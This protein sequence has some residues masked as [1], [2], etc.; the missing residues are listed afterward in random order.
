LKQV[1]L[2]AWLLAG[3]LVPGGEPARAQTGSPPGV[4]H[5]PSLT[6]ETALRLT[7]EHNPHVQA[8]RLQADAA[9]A[10]RDD[11]GRRPNP[12]L[13]VG[14]ENIGGG[15]LGD[16]RE[17]QLVLS[18]PIELGGDRAA[19]TGLAAARLDAARAGVASAAID[20]EALTTEL[21]LDAWV[22]QESLRRLAEAVTLAREAV[23]SATERLNAGAAPAYERTRATSFM[24]LR[25]VEH[26]RAATALEAAL[27]RLLQQWSG[28][29][30]FDS[31]ALGEPPLE[32]PAA[33]EILRMRGARH[34]DRLKAEAAR[35]EGEWRVRHARALRTPDLSVDAGVRRLEGPDATGFVVG[36]A[37]PLP[38]WNSARGMITAA[39]AER[40]AAGL[41]AGALERDLDRRLRVTRARL[42]TAL[43]Q[44]DRLQAGAAPAA[45][46]AMEQIRS[47]YRVGRLGYLD[48]QEGQR[49]LLEIELMRIEAHAEVWRAS[50]ELGRLTAAAG[51]TG[52]TR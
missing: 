12:V 35:R 41:E 20:Q 38:L 6:L 11:A 13:S 40:E 27:D 21:F 51:D 36:I 15:V 4:V 30:T 47:A 8:A 33:L 34:P 19:R 45:E 44:L 31:L 7:R 16:A 48:I 43:Q 1:T 42:L 52:E 49:S 24:A 22:S 50:T 5:H 2:A 46:E 10:L 17:S 28:A 39:A 37:V 3:C 14:V 9:G 18:Q 25:E 23:A 29:A 26:A 32:E